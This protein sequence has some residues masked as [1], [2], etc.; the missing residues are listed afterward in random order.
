MQWHLIT[1]EYPP[2]RGGVSDYTYLLALALAEVGE[3]VHIWTPTVSRDVDELA[4]VEVHL[5]PPHFGLRWLLALHRGLAALGNRGT[6][7]VQ[8]VPHMYGWKAMNLAFCFWLA[9]QRK[10]KKIWVMFHEVAFPFRSHQ[11]WKHDLLAVVHRLMAWIV[12]HSA[13]KVVHL[14]R[15]LQSASYE[16]GSEGAN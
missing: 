14:D 11:P 2:K 4:S 10:K 15:T 9:L 3:E 12:L 1:G 16:A 8:Y 5:L 6:V 7:L 13:R